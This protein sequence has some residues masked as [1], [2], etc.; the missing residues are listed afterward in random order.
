MRESWGKEQAMVEV[1]VQHKK[2]KT[3]F[4]FLDK[5]FIDITKDVKDCDSEERKLAVINRLLAKQR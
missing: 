2:K 3:G 1:R 5:K 4:R